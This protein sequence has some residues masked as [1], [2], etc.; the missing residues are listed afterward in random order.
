MLLKLEKISS[1]KVVAGCRKTY[2]SENIGR[3]ALAHLG[4]SLDANGLI[5]AD[6]VVPSAASGKYSDW[7]VNG[8]EVIRKDLPKE[9]HYR[10]I[11]SPN[12]GDE[13]WC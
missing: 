7:N 6:R 11:E 3:G 10:T 1:Q 8:K 13:R 5:V 2:N 12:W 9:T 4:V